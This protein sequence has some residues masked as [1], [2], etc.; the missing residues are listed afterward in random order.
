MANSQKTTRLG[1]IASAESGVL[2]GWREEIRS[3]LEQ[4]VQEIHRIVSGLQAKTRDEKVTKPV[5]SRPTEL[6]KNVPSNTQP[7]SASANRVNREPTTVA[8]EN[9]RGGPQDSID[10]SRTRLEN[11][12]RRLSEQLRTQ[13]VTVVDAN[14]RQREEPHS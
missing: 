8:A 11:L 10:A 12:K 9:T 6:P 5:A 14:E 3:F 7:A 1:S 13:Q 2:T 4:T